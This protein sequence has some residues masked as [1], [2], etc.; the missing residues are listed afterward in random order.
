MDFRDSL[1]GYKPKASGLE[2]GILKSKDEGKIGMFREAMA[3]Q[4]ESR[5]LKENRL[6]MHK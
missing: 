3:E 2:I 4:K 6:Q 5:I 1:K